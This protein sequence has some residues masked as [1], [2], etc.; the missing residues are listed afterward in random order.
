MPSANFDIRSQLT[1]MD[2]AGLEAVCTELDEPTYRADQL[3][4]WIYRH[5]VDSFE[6]MDNLPQTFRQTLSERYTLRNL[7]LKH[8]TDSEKGGTRKFLFSTA[9]EKL[10][11]SVLIRDGN[12]RTLCV[13]SQVGCALDCTFCATA[14]MGFIKNLSAGE[15]VEQYLQVQNQI[16]DRITNIVFMGMGEPFINYTRVIR[17]AYLLND[18]DGINIG[19]RKITISTSGV[20]PKIRQFT[21]EDH[22]FKL[23]I[24]LNASSDTIRSE[25]MPINRTYPLEEL[26]N[27]ARDYAYRSSNRITFEYVLLNKINDAPNDARRLKSLLSGFSCKVNIIPYNEIGGTYQRPPRERI[28]AFLGELADASFTVTV[29]WSGGDKIKA[30]CG[31][32]AAEALA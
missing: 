4:Q 16:Q 22:R 23:A 14:S 17:A 24:S 19:A 30:G 9:D 1:G 29:R 13:S 11:E 10:L 8:T 25:I 3:F 26:L 5:Q 7:T 21:T 32:L 12:R 27:A 18:T 31:Q 2:H 6:K 20:V 15:I 28:D